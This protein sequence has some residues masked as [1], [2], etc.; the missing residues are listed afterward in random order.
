[1]K[2][3]IILLFFLLKITL[4]SSQ[5]LLLHYS[6]DGNTKDV[7]GNNNDGTSFGVT[8]GQ[9]RMGQANSAAYFDG[10]D[11]FIELPNLL[12]LK[13]ELPLSFSFW[14]K[15]SS[16]DYEDRA[17]FNTSFEE[18]VNS[19]VFLTTQSSTGKYAVGYGNG[20]A[21]YTSSNRRGF[22]SNSVIDN[23][24][25][26][27]QIIIESRSSMKIVV[28]CNDL[29]GVYSGTANELKYSSSSGVIG[30]HDQNNGLSAYH[31]KGYI[32]DFKYY[33]GVIDVNNIITPVFSGLKSVLCINEAYDLPLTSDNSIGGSW[34]PSIDNSTEGTTEYTFT[35][36]SSSGCESSTTHEITVVSSETPVFSGLKSV[37]C[38]NEAYDLPLTS[39]NSIGGSW[40][41]SIDNSTE[42]T[43]EYTFT[44]SSSSGCVSSTTH[45]ITVVSSETPVFSGLKSVLCI[46]E[47]YDLPLTSDNSIG[48]S[49]SPSIDNSTEGTTEY[50]FT[51]S[52][53]SGCVSSTT[54]EITVVSSETP[55]FSGL[56]SVLCINEAY[57]LPLTSDNSIGGSWSPSIDNSTEGTTE[58]TFTSS[59]SIGC[60]SS[61]THEIT[62]VS[63]E[64]PVFSGLM[65]ELYYGTDYVLP[66]ISDNLI[67][68]TWHPVFDNQKIGSTNYTFTPEK[69]TCA[70]EVAFNIMILN[71]NKINIPLFFT[72]NND[73]INDLWF[74]EGLEG[75]DR[76]ELLIYDRFGKVL[77]KT[78]SLSNWKG[79]DGIF[80]GKIMPNND[81]W[82]FLKGVINNRF[83][84]K[85]G[86]FSL[87]N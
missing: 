46:N 57:D 52:S 43:T 48:G 25:H 44:P 80:K 37:L 7:S 13:P 6:F 29:G 55:V 63:S 71:L 86:H 21:N 26:F 68:G 10:I 27:V 31:F 69:G 64:T 20:T 9:D 8:F 5:E 79:W 30:K 53:S 60:V 16:S 84:S 73:D 70:K 38:I 40:S 12:N 28:D 3:K 58:Y 18:D 41:P 50:T 62:V 35:P 56:K 66:E 17:V 59:S 14:I 81:Y 83:Y 78:I 22:V 39:D 33:K 65:N 4:V 1:M 15:Y 87:L 24:W 82:Y 61:I 49:W 47:A 36:S 42:G 77:F 23:E 34:S 19:G 32:D 75:F 45:K 72:P 67:K 2:K 85:E 51:P 11:D 54:H 76:G 74:I